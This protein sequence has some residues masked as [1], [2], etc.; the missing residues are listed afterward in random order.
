MARAGAALSSLEHGTRAAE[1]SVLDW[2]GGLTKAG[3]GLHALTEMTERAVQLGKDAVTTQARLSAQISGPLADQLRRHSEAAV[4]ARESAPGRPARVRRSRTPSPP[5]PDRRL[6]IH[7][8][9][10]RI[11]PVSRRHRL[12]QNRD[13]T[14]TTLIDLLVQIIF[15]LALILVSADV[16]GN[17]S[18]E[19]GWVPPG[20]EDPDQHLGCRSPDPPG[21]PRPGRGDQEHVHPDEGRPARLR[22][23][24]RRVRPTG[25][26]R[27][28]EPT[29][30]PFGGRRHGGGRGDHPCDGRILVGLGVTRESSRT[31]A[32]RADASTSRFP[33]SDWRSVPGSWREHGLGAGSFVRVQGGRT[34]RRARARRRAPSISRPRGPSPATSRCRRR[35]GASD[36]ERAAPGTPPRS[37]RTAVGAPDRHRPPSVAPGNPPSVRARLAAPKGRS[38]P[39]GNPRRHGGGSSPTHS[40]CGESAGGPT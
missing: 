20:P 31:T 10:G 17:E 32:A 5:S 30:P 15:V 39:H 16:M 35:R 37:R 3:A 26:T 21:R 25:R 34:L 6:T 12:A 36:E 2:S 24:D 11:A 4:R 27:S 18:R 23:E 22:R 38:T 13:V 33:P 28:G 1:Q 40:P 14:L 7:S 19:R 8:Q 9:Q 29:V